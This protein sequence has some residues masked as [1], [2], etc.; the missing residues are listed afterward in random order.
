MYDAFSSDYDRFVDWDSR[1][2]VE[3]PFL[4]ER[5]D[6][7]ETKLGRKP[8]LLDAACGTGR[9]TIRLAQA[10][11]PVAGADISSGM[12]AQARLNAEA[13]GVKTSFLAAGFSDLAGS[14]QTHP[15]YPFDV[16]ICLGNSLPHV[17]N[18]Q[19]LDDALKNFA[20]CLRPGGFL[21]VQ[22]R[23]FDAVM[24]KRLRWMDPQ[25]YTQADHDWVFVRFYDFL[26]DGLIQFNV[27]TLKREATAAGWKQ[28]LYSTRLLPLSKAQLSA[29][30]TQTGF[31]P[32]DYFGSLAGEAFDAQTS[33]NL[34]AAAW[35]KGEG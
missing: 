14:F 24:S 28:I 9:H 7:L 16:L 20:R 17:L 8:H 32:I 21:L 19:E 10:D 25:S 23:N 1:L 6:V 12:V 26:S 3:M 33:G 5:L 30:L 29:S 34:I 13:A 11:Y 31:E 27:L 2:T 35:L 22:N 4:L 15:L 18:V